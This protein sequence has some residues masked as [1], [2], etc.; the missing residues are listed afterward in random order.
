MSQ[1]PRI[2]SLKTPADLRSHAESLEMESLGFDNQSGH[3]TQSSCA[4]LPVDDEVDVEALAS[5]IELPSGVN[6]AAIGNRFTILPME[7]WDGTR[8]GRPSE[9]TRRRWRNFGLSGAKW[10]WGGEAVAVRHDGR[11]NPNQLL[12]NPANAPEIGG[13]RELLV[14]SHAE[15]FGSTDD[16]FV[17]LQLTHSGRWARPNDKATAEPRTVQRNCRV[18]SSVGHHG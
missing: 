14:A 2:A 8:D 9:L 5:P 1:Y 12:M 11:A 13:L 17:G 6:H 10:I 16:L 4:R 7:G 18:G 3:S 15:R